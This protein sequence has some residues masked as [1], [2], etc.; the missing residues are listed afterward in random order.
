MESNGKRIISNGDRSL[1]S[2]GPIIF[3]GAGTDA[4]H[5]FFQLLH[6]GTK[7]VSA[8]F[9]AFRKSH[10]HNTDHHVALLA[11]F[12]G[13]TEALMVG[14]A[15]H[16]IIEEMQEKGSPK[17]VIDRVADHKICVGSK[18]SNVLLFNKLNPYTLGQLI[19]LY[20]HKVFVQGVLWDINSFDQMGVELGKELAL[21]IEKEILKGEIDEN[22]HDPS[23]LALLKEIL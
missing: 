22:A 14:K 19:A 2:T 23:T 15:R 3:G 21:K 18:P 20:E 13:Q 12:I 10:R 9:I 16:Q 7:G 5:S 1:L 17:S 4:Q 6:Q 8:D 11:N